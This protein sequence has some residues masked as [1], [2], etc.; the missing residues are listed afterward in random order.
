[1]NTKPKIVNMGEIDGRKI[2]GI[3]QAD[4]KY[5]TEFADVYEETLKL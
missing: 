1:M 3:L 5:L 2:I 4:G